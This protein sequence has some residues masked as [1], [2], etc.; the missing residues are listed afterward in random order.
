MKKKIWI[1]IAIISLIIVMVGITIYRQVAAKGPEV[2]II[3]AKFEQISEH[4]MI[5]GTL[6]LEQQQ[7]VYY[8]PDKGKVANY[9]VK[10]GQR[11]EPGIA[12]IKYNQPQLEFE[13][14]QN[15][16]SLESAYLKINQVK[17]Q[18]ANLQDKEDE[19]A[20]TV[21]RDKA[22]EQF[23]SEKT[24]LQTERKMANIDLKQAELQKKNIEQQMKDLSV[25]SEVTGTVLSINKQAA[26]GSQEG[27]AEP[28][29]MIGQLGGL[30]ST[31]FITEYDSVKVK[32]GQNVT[33]RSDAIPNQVWTGTVSE[34]SMLPKESAVN[35]SNDGAAAQ[36]PIKV[37]VK[38][39]TNL[40]R[41]GFQLIMEIAT[42]QKDALTIPM[43][44]VVTKGD[45]QFV[46]I[47][48]KKIAKKVE[49]KTGITSSEKIEITKGL[50]KNEK[51]IIQPPETLKDG[52]EVTLK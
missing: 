25:V 31:G 28:I 49:V 45:K 47:L 52:M 12:L 51:V 7:K 40:L 23:E 6:K 11:V 36:Y 19:L 5:P 27:L 17:D 41:P 4:L 35:T 38:D 18:L 39:S 26:N 14:E 9:F 10:E 1:A 32:R 34:I 21:G 50:K 42:E 8:S 24:N 29:I 20:K 16:L 33:L 37:M 22:K 46:F 48:N 2:K 3:Q 44:A 15:K 43:E 30:T 13:L